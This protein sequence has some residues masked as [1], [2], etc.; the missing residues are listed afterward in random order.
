MKLSIMDLDARYNVEHEPA[1]AGMDDWLAYCEGKVI[2]FF[3]TRT[4]AEHCCKF[5]N[6]EQMCLEEA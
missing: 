5:H 6:S 3:K 4:L 1:L 2:G